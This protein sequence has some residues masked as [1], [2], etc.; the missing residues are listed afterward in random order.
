MRRKKNIFSTPVAK[1]AQDLDEGKSG[2]ERR[3]KTIH[4]DEVK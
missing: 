4:S 3:I 2:F 1:V